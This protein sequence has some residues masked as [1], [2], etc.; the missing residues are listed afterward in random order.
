VDEERI[1]E[2]E[3][4]LPSGAI[5]NGYREYDVQD[6]VLKRHKI[7]FL[8]AEYV[9]VEGKT[10]VGKLPKEDQGHYFNREQRV[11][12]RRTKSNLA[13]RFRN[14]HIHTH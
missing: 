11:F 6:L 4:K 10:I 2:P 5:F 8:L 12:S 7:R 9:T 13:G 14:S 3:E 1:I